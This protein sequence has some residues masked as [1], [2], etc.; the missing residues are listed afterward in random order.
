[1]ESDPTPEVCR[2]RLLRPLKLALLYLR[3]VQKYSS[4]FLLCRHR[5]GLF[6]A[7]SL[8]YFLFTSL[9]PSFLHHSLA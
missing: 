7:C 4:S 3:N 8:P 1:M 5:R 2:P 9:P 6:A